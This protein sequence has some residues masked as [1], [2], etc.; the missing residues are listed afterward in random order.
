MSIVTAPREKKTGRC[1][2]SF[3]IG[4]SGWSCFCVGAI[5][6]AGPSSRGFNELVSLVV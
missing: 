1:L 4:L 5:D 2:R 3:V 6:K